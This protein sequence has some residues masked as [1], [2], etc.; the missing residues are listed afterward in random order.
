MGGNQV[1]TIL[2]Y[3]DETNQ[4]KQFEK[5]LNNALK[6][7]KRDNEFVVKRLDEKKF[8]NSIKQLED[9]QD[10]LR[11]E[12]EFCNE[13]TEF[14]NAS[15][16][17]IDYDLL[18]SQAGKLLT[19]EIVAYIVRCFTNCKMVIGLN[20]YGRNT[21]DLTLKGHPGSFADLNLGADQLSNP[22][23][24][25]GCWGNLRRGY[26]PWSWPNLSDFVHNFDK[27]VKDVKENL[28]TPIYKVIGFDHELLQLLP[29]TI[30]QF[31]GKDETK[32]PDQVTFRDF[33]IKSEN[34]LRPKDAAVLNNGIN[35]NIL[36]RVGAARISKWLER[37]IIPEQDILVDAP[38][39][40]S[41]YPSLI[42]GDRKQI[43]TWNQ[44]ANLVEYS[45]LGLRTNLIE[46]YRFEK[47][48]WISRPVWFWSKL[49]ECD[50]IKEIREPWG[51]EIPNWVFCE[52]ASRFY[53]R[54]NCKEFLADTVSPFTRRFAKG[55]E[56]VDY[57]PKFRFAL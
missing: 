6:R 51:T 40:I 38:H 26:R 46:P 2:V 3:D 11:K 10:K 19:G 21:F 7:A 41:R 31:I 23:L 30:V 50:I 42:T 20:Q 57:R 8:K 29:H 49:R 44:T 24:W 48:Y 5:K 37:H 4:S 36:A 45:K 47:D 39:L 12:E 52:D 53:E 32:E 25:R 55:F 33:V 43:E 18:Y 16:F 22:D 15:I 9:R 28:D 17:I 27:R 54:R 14:D 13:C 1:K 34:A 35:D 56:K